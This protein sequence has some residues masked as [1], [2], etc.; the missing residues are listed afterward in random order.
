MVSN[1]AMVVALAGAQPVC[2]NEAVCSA[3][4]GESETAAA[5]VAAA[6]QG[7]VPQDQ[8]QSGQAADD[9]QIVVT[10]EIGAPEGDPAEALNAATYEVVE[11]IDLAVVEPIAEAY[12]KGIP[13]PVRSGLRNVL[14]NL[15]E[16]INFLNFLL[17]FKPGRALKT[18]GR[19]TINT[20]LGIGG[21]F[22]PA[23]KKFDLEYEQNGL[24]NTLG[25]YGIGP[26][27]YLYLPFIGSTT[28]RDLAG[29][30]VDL[31]IIPA[32][33]GRPFNRPIY[34]IPVAT[35]NS[36]ESRIETDDQIDAIRERCGD[37]YGANRDIYLIQRQL[38]IDALRGKQ[39]DDLDEL[40]DRLEFNCDIDILTAGGLTPDNPKQ[41]VDR[42]T[43]LLGSQESGAVT[44]ET[45]PAEGGAAIEASQ[46][47]EYPT[48]SGTSSVPTIQFVSEPVV[49]PTGSEPGASPT[50]MLN[51]AEARRLAN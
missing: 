39:S 27:P 9:D 41:F 21:L 31:S 49:Q 4:P 24:A 11:A 2:D 19:F 42:N 3:E 47:V 28:V 5:Q 10:G 36:L 7:T 20:T 15:G 26:G 51:E 18:L 37:P 12:D 46:T 23:T 29:R 32:V 50:D 1:I 44:S 8:E 40:V 43:T 16:P 33:A 35:L 22:D 34:T 17:Q 48:T 30:I 6:E 14:R 45:V 13:K 38:E 25:Y